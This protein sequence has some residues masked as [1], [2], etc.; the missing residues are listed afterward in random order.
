MID[1]SVLDAMR[2][3]LDRSA[4]PV[5]GKRGQGRSVAPC[6]PRPAPSVAF[7]DLDGTMVKGHMIFDFPDHLVR[8]GLFDSQK[9]KEIVQQRKDF[10]A[11]KITYRNVAERLPTLY[12][13]GVRGQKTTAMMLEA[14]KFV[15]CRMGNV[16]CYAKG[17]V[18]LMK[19]HGR[20]SIAVSGSPRDT[21]GALA[22]RLGME[23]GLGT[24]LEAEA[25]RFTGRVGSNFILE[26]TKR[27]CFR[28][29]VEELGLD[30]SACFGFGDTE[31]DLSFLSGV[32][33][34]VAL[35]PSAELRTMALR[36]G[37][38]IFERSQDVVEGVRKLAVKADAVQ[39]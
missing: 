14:E 7:F 34:P 8:A 9:Y 25:G 5:R 27:A 39:G 26:E 2:A 29:L 31:Q 19:E 33:H 10:R 21:V 11:K 18:M 24:E 12:A 30:A 17:L 20:P 36:K 1:R 3:A 16:F 38:N 13:E 6:A 28:E 32:G 37:W 22:R 35:N 23:A 15:E 4:R